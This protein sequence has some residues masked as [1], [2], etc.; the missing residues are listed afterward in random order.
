ML[1]NIMRFI[2]NIPGKSCLAVG[3][4]I[5]ITLVVVLLGIPTVIVDWVLSEKDYDIKKKFKELCD[6]YKDGIND[7]FADAIRKG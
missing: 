5:L 2:F 7:A 6:F 1:K 3:Q 4:M